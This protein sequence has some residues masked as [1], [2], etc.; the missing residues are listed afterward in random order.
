MVSAEPACP[1]GRGSTPRLD[2]SF[3]LVLLSKTVSI[4][5][6]TSRRDFNGIAA[7]ATAAFE[8]LPWSVAVLDER[9][10]ILAV[11]EPGV[12]PPI[13]MSWVSRTMVLA[14]TI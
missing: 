13:E 8:A 1:V 10:A 5:Q 12:M 9:G 11:T 2:E 3:N 6:R 4:S 14:P 7:A